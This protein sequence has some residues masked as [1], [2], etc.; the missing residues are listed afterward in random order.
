MDVSVEA[1]KRIEENLFFQRYR[2]LKIKETLFS[3][4]LTAVG[5]LQQ[6]IVK[7]AY[8]DMIGRR[9]ISV[10]KTTEPMERFPL[11]SKA[12]GYILAEG[13]MIRLS[14]DKTGCVTINMDQY[15][16]S[17]EQ[18]TKEFIED[19]QPHAIDN[20]ERRLS[21]ALALHET[22]TVLG[23]YNSI[24][25]AD[26]AGGSPLNWGNRQ[27]DWNA[28]MA[29]HSAVKSANWKPTVL[30]LNS[31]QLSQL[32]LDNHFLE[33]EYLPSKDVDLEEGLI[34]KV[35]GMQVESS[36][37]VPNGTAYAIDASI[38]GIMLL[39]RDITVEDYSDVMANRYGMK[40]TTRFGL[41]ILRSNAVAKMTN[42]KT[43][44]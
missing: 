36:T 23:L 13:S 43:T 38:A 25:A 15:A 16:E 29:L 10:K 30:V 19:A 22:E 31:T 2:D 11:A 1:K 42:I 9:I 21:Q 40:A 12:V 3:D 4:T 44:L 39:R 17:S 6:Q 20:I 37:L 27:M 5:H 14:G 24:A 7:Y 33:Y 26:L 35:M 41:G 28:V 18:W 34:R 32:L 8:P